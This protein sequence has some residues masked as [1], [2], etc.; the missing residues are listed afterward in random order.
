MTSKHCKRFDGCSTPICPLDENGSSIIVWYA[1]EEIC[2]LR[3]FCK[4]TLVKTQTKIA[5]KA[6]DF[7]TFYTGRMLQHSFIIGKALH[8]IDSETEIDSID[9][10]V[11]KWLTEHPEKRIISESEKKKLRENMLTVRQI[12]TPS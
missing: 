5:K 6:R 2:P 4:T 8:G 12:N 1:D 9:S 7:D 3:E 11:E 10:E